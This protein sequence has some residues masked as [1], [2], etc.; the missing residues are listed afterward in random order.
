MEPECIGI[1]ERSQ[2]PSEKLD[3]TVDFEHALTRF[4]LPDANYSAG[5]KVRS[6]LAPGFQF[7]S[8][9]GHTSNKEPRWPTAIGGTVQDG[10][11]TWTAEALTTASLTSTVSGTPAWT[12]D[13]AAITIGS[14]S[15]VGQA[16]TAFLSGGQDGQT[17]QALCTATMADGRIMVGVIKLSIMRQV[18]C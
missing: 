7:S 3:Y 5:V 1:I 18:A 8:S 15:I 4:R 17:F 11:I 9:G 12:V 16:G 14:P 6:Q 13:N 2:D 10:S